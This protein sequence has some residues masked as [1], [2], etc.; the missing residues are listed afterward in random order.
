MQLKKFP[1]N[2]VRYA[3]VLVIGTYFIHRLQYPWS[4]ALVS[5][6]PQPFIRFNLE[7]FIVGAALSF[8]VV[9]GGILVDKYGRRL[10]W[11]VSRFLYGASILMWAI[12]YVGR[13]TSVEFLLP[14]FLDIMWALSLLAAALKMS[15]VAWL[16]DIEGRDGM[17]NAYGLLYLSSFPL[18]LAGLGLGIFLEDFSDDPHVSIL[19]AG[20]IMIAVGFWIF[21]FP[22][23]YGDREKSLLNIAK[24]GITQFKTSRVLQ[25]IVIQ[26]ILIDLPLWVKGTWKGYLVEEF[27]LS[28]DETFKMLWL[29]TVAIAFLAGGFLLLVKGIDYKKLIVYPTICMA[30]L[31]LLMPLARSPQVFTILIGGVSAVALLRT[32]GILILMNDAISENR[33]TVLSLVTF[34][35][36]ITSIASTF[37]YVSDIQW[38]ITFLAAGAFALISLVPVAAALKIHGRNASG[39]AQA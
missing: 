34:L 39:S 26:G 12:V 24:N 36:M 6:I 25:L 16:F 5:R 13:G 9:I 7:S 30:G 28:S 32:A 2:V 4:A 35:I 1:P 15:W 20:L 19:L 22:E 31:Y 27:N 37:W 17:K 10:S 33:A 18:I 8:S 11:A 29:I 14:M 23:N 21:T 3:G 38:D